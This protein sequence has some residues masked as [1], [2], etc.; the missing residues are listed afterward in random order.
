MR[1]NEEGFLMA[2]E[3]LTLVY[4]VTQKYGFCGIPWILII[5]LTAFVKKNL[6]DV[7][8]ESYLTYT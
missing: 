5:Q 4:F 2:S 3:P 1:D 8:N 7:E 6:L